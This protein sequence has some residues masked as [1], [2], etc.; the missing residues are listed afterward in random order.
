ML[1]YCIKMAAKVL[2]MLR[3]LYGKIKLKLLQYVTYLP[4]KMKDFEPLNVNIAY[5]IKK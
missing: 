4:T 2:D 3:L 1:F 5:D